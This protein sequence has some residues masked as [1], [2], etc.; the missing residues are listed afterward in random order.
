MSVTLLILLDLS[1]GF[2]TIDHGILLGQLSELGVGGTALQLFHSY[3][4][5]WLQKVVLGE[6]CLAP[7]ILQYGVPQGSVLPPCCSTSI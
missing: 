6:H 3:L 1:A 7:W 2:D 4:E 5:G